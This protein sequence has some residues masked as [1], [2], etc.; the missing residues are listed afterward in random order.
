MNPDEV[1]RLLR[2]AVEE[3]HHASGVDAR[4]VAGERMVAGWR[5]LDG[6]LSMGGFLPADWS[7]EEAPS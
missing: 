3:Y 6:W 4:T 2:E 5:A 7:R 1:L